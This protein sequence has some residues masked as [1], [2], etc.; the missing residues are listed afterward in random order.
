MSLAA[1]ASF[2]AVL[3]VLVGLALARGRLP[4]RS[5][6]PAPLGW[7]DLA[8][9]LGS[10]LVT[11]IVGAWLV[12]PRF[13]EGGVV[14]GADFQEYCASVASLRGDASEHWYPMRSKLAGLPAAL[15]ARPLGVVD[16]LGAAALVGSG[17][18]GAGL[19]GWGR[20]AHGRLAGLLAVAFGLALP[21]LALAGRLLSFYP[22][23][24]GL[25][26]VA[27]ASAVAAMRWRSLPA[28]ALGGTGLGLALLADGIGLVWA[29]PLAAVVVAAALRASPRRWPVRLTSVLLPLV[30]SWF[31][32]RWAN[33]ATHPLELQLGIMVSTNQAQQVE[34]S[35]LGAAGFR[36]GHG[37]P[38]AAPAT[39]LRVWRASDRAGKQL[40]AQGGVSQARQHRVAPLLPWV[41]AV[42][43]PFAWGAR[44]RP[45]LLAACGLACTPY[46]VMLH[47]A[48]TMETNLRFLLVALP[49]V[50]VILALALAWS[51]LGPLPRQGDEAEPAAGARWAPI[52]CSLAAGALAVFV[53][54]GPGWGPLSLRWAGHHPFVAVNDATSAVHFAVTGERRPN[55]VL[56]PCIDGLRADHARGLPAESRL[57]GSLELPRDPR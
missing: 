28:L 2:S 42:L 55:P 1:I 3:A 48:A 24:V 29:F 57:Y 4:G 53:L 36:W 40:Q 38:L 49:F 22:V 45:W 32:G 25:L 6:V 51:C 20:A 15:L 17:L 50:P 54:L 18:L 10:A 41:A 21:A 46:A 19:F 12:G 7:P 26:A 33:A 9:L 11:A 8:L 35:S 52:A 44:R 39:V 37:N 23:I 30:L 27:S 31:V 56:E 43:L 14:T 34:R 16:G 47:R 5:F 13:L